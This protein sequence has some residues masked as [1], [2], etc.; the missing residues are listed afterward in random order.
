MA[1]LV[2]AAR[3]LG[4]A[5]GRTRVFETIATGGAHFREATICTLRLAEPDG[6]RLVASAAP[7]A[8]PPHAGTL[9][10]DLSRHVLRRARPLLVRAGGADARVARPAL[11]REWGY[12]IYYGLP[13]P[14][15]DGPI[16]VLGLILP[17]GAPAPGAE[18]RHLLEMYAAQAALALQHDA[19]VAT[20]DR[21]HQALEVARA[22]LYEAAKLLALG[23]LVS[24]VV[25]EVSNLL[26]SITLRME[27]LLGESRDAEV[28]AQLQTLDA[29]CRQI[30]ALIGELRRFSRVADQPMI[31][32]DLDGLVD[33]LV[34][35]RRLRMRARGVQIERGRGARPPMI[36]GDHAQIERAVLALLLES[37][38]ALG[39]AGGGTIVIATGIRDTPGGAW[40]W[41]T[42]EDDG[43]AVPAETLS[44]L[45]DPFAPRGP[46]RGPSIT[47]AAAQA[48]V[49]AHRGRLGVAN[50]P[51]GGVVFRLELPVAP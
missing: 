50:R 44:R 33:H 37:E 10:D 15:P 32:V 47:L 30:G 7:A 2:A 40:V 14:G 8:A 22:E 18:E 24:D 48:T 43:P 5:A 34:D 35:L 49:T 9:D 42:V 28:A 51:G 1:H 46:G 19:L 39:G 26:G 3:A 4:A 25:H 38:E 11:W 36:R 45:F 20:V 21:Q 23:H 29:H 6:L 17:A 27:S 16:G 12:A 41:L 31:G 13:L